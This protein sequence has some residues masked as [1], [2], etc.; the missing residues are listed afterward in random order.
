MHS[1]SIISVRSEQDRSR[2]PSSDAGSVAEFQDARPRLFGIAYRMLR[3]AADAEDIVQD[4]WLRWQG[5]DRTQVRD[6][7]AFLVT[8]TTR[9][10]LNATSSARARH[11]VLVDRWLPEQLP[12]G[13]DPSLSTERAAAIEHAVLHLLQRLT[14]TERAVFVL[15]EAFAYPFRDIAD[16][17]G[18]S[19]TNARQLCHRARARIAEPRHE[20][21]PVPRAEHERLVRAFIDAAQNGSV[22]HLE[23]LLAA[24]MR[25]D[26]S[27]RQP[28]PV[29]L[30][31][32]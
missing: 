27:R 5:A 20:H 29:A 25:S 1:T 12:P 18:V 21:E 13:E 28:N 23:R 11:E 26:G 6:R 14:P 22:T 8:I 32:R 16:R 15:R 10:T 30:P 31:G 17:L 7:I 24:D 9:V 4:V 3:R 2:P 19:E